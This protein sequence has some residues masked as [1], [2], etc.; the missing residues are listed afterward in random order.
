MNLAKIR[1]QIC[2]KHCFVNNSQQ[3]SKSTSSVTKK[4]IAQESSSLNPS[5]SGAK[6]M[7]RQKKVENVNLSKVMG[8]LIKKGQ[9]KEALKE[10]QSYERYNPERFCDVVTRNQALK[11]CSQLGEYKLAKEIFHKMKRNFSRFGQPNVISYNTMIHIYSK[12]ERFEKVHELFELMLDKKITPDNSTVAALFEMY[13][14]QN[15]P[16]K[17][18]RLLS[19][20]ES[21]YLEP[22]AKTINSI[23]NMY[24]VCKKPTK[25]H[26]FMND[27]IAK[28]NFKPDLVTYS[29]LMDMY[30]KSREVTKVEKL[31]QN[32]IAEGIE[33]DC[34][35]YTILLDMYARCNGENAIQKAI[36]IYELMKEKNIEMDLIAYT[37]LI[38]NFARHNEA[39]IVKD[40]YRD[41][42]LKGFE[43][44]SII[45]TAMTSFKE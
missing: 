37:V 11:C 22:D 12:Q 33:S 23:I 24:N 35:T 2:F 18:E 15:E 7:F 17:G 4:F 29:I 21:I 10:F 6:A 34:K 27:M 44:N 32:M 25:A 8:A 45:S 31:L 16:E 1:V 42:L 43:P 20:M 3:F 40:I 36:M 13:G 28:G 19:I 39:K 41:F 38:E 14:L 9:Y 26:H 30:G 5:I